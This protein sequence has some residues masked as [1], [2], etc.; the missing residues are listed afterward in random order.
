MCHYTWLDW[1]VSLGSVGPEQYWELMKWD[2]DGHLAFPSLVSGMYCFD[3]VSNNKGDFL[4]GYVSRMHQKEGL[5]FG[6]SPV[7]AFSFATDAGLGL[8][9]CTVPSLV[10]MVATTVTGV[11]S[12]ACSCAQLSAA[13][14]RTM[15]GCCAGA[16]CKLQVSLSQGK[17]PGGKNLPENY[18]R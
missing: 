12:T 9:E 5:C 14:S 4:P 16:V 18:W 17:P 13:L 2:G 3:F 10:R 11:M 1:F 7:K 15:L 8:H 6:Y